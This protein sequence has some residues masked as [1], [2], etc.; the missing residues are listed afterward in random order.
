MICT[1]EQQA[2][3]D[4][5]RDPLNEEQKLFVCRM[6]EAVVRGQGGMFWL[7]AS[8]GCGKSYATRVL[9]E[10][11]RILYGEDS[12]LATAYQATAAS[13][14]D[15]RGRT[16][17]S[18]FSLARRNDSAANTFSALGACEMLNLQFANLRMLILDE[19]STL[20]PKLF[21]W[22][23]KRLMQHSRD[24]DRDFGGIVLVCVGDFLQLPPVTGGV[25]R[26]RTLADVAMHPERCLK[27]DEI[28]AAVLMRKL[29][30]I[31]FMQQIRASG[32]P[33]HMLLLNKLRRTGEIRRE[34]I[35]SIET[36]SLEDLA[37][38][39]FRLPL[40]LHATNARRIVAGIDALKRFAQSRSLPVIAWWCSFTHSK[41]MKADDLAVFHANH[42][43]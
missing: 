28:S 13:I 1:A 25:G 41:T 33:K 23:N 6:L 18:S 36:L 43:H 26:S 38:D 22:I 8:A 12:V 42:A 17:I 10:S 34:D 20:T 27:E 21:S 11:M 2:R 3:V 4:K 32:C 40:S 7:S 31:V 30:R 29:V 24:Y 9:I 39:K 5:L 37:S 15:P 16:V 35:D 14:T 19:F